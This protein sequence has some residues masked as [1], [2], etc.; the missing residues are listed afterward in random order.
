MLITRF[1][2]W[3]S[4]GTET[5][6]HTI[7]TRQSA[8]CRSVPIQI[9]CG[10][11]R[12]EWRGMEINLLKVWWLTTHMSRTSQSCWGSPGAVIVCSEVLIANNSKHTYDDLLNA[13][14]YLN[15]LV[16][17]NPKT[18]SKQRSVSFY[19]STMAA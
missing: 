6:Y 12:H 17:T 5:H 16:L 1:S 13:L 7:H 4:L 15:F 14:G 9:R 10:I 11:F 3:Y 2:S 19:S 18:W 8:P